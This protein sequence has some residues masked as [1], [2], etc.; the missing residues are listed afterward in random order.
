M[1]NNT[2][3]AA[4]RIYF[5]YVIFIFRPSSTSSTAWF[6]NVRLYCG[7]RFSDLFARAGNYNAAVEISPT[8]CVCVCV[9]YKWEIYDLVHEIINN[10][11]VQ[12]QQPLKTYTRYIVIIYLQGIAPFSLHDDFI[13][14]EYSPK[15]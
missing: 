6:N 1:Y 15:Q 14:A 5:I 3:T 9:L 11:V 2:Y 10:R 13:T 4:P 12:Q 7:R 8:V